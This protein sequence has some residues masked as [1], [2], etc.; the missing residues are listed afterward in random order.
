MSRASSTSVHVVR[1]ELVARHHALDDRMSSAHDLEVEAVGE[2]RAR[3]PLARRDIRQRGEHVEL[4]DDARRTLHASD[5]APDRCTQRLEQRSLA[6]LDAL[7]RRQHLFFVLLQRRRDEAF[8]AGE[9]L[10]SLI[11]RRYEVAVRVRD[12]DEVA[13]HPV[14]SDL[15]RRNAGARTLFGLNRRDGVLSAIAQRSKLVQ[16]GVDAP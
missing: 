3:V 2:R 5:L 16:L 8:G 7:R 13:E 10:T 4:R 14:E 6:R 12:F 15:E 11:V 1:D 9:R